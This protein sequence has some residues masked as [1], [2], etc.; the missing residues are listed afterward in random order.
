[1][2]LSK[3]FTM[4][5]ESYVNFV[6]Q[7]YRLVSYVNDHVPC[8][9]SAGSTVE[10]SSIDKHWFGGLESSGWLA[11]VHSCLVA[12]KEVT[13]LLCIKRHCAML[14]GKVWLIL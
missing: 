1:M 10:L 13:H 4:L 12:A 6:L 11:M 2:A 14:L 8:Y 3:I 5:F 9:M 7:V